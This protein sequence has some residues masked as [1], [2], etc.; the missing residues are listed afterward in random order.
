[1][2]T[3]TTTIDARRSKR[4]AFDYMANFSNAADWDP[5]VAHA[6]KT[7]AGPVGLGTVFRV[8][9]KVPGRTVDFM[10]E[11]VEFD[12]P[13]RVVLRAETPLLVSNDTVTVVQRGRYSTVEYKA[14]LSLKGPL[15]VF[16]PA[17]RAVF[18]QIGDRAAAGLREALTGPVTASASR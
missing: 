9:V 2:A 3:Y 15:K 16:D 12:E 7:T 17:L 18:G 5:G 10:Y 8:G 11:I 14:V 6:E 4:D 13:D 1:M